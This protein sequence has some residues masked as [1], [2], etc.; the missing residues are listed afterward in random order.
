MFCVGGRIVR[1]WIVHFWI[2]Q[3]IPGFANLSWSA[4]TY[5]QV[6]TRVGDHLGIPGVFFSESGVTKITSLLQVQHI[7]FPRNCRSRLQSYLRC[8]FLQTSISASY[9]RLL[10]AWQGTCDLHEELNK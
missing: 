4:K 2:W 7:S 8:L 9:V 1:P 5:A 10:G 6:S 3:S